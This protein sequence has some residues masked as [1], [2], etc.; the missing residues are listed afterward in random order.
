MRKIPT[1]A[2]RE[3][4]AYFFSPI[5]Y[6]V[7]MLFLAAAGFFFHVILVETQEATLRHTL[8][9]LNFIMI[10]VAPVLTMRLLAEEKRAGTLETL[11]TAP[12]TDWEV[13]LGKYLACVG[14]YLMLLLPTLVYVLILGKLGSPDYRQIATGYLGLILL[15]SLFLSFGMIA[16]ALTTNQIVAALL[17]FVPLLILWVV[18]WVV[19]EPERYMAAS[20]AS[21]RILK[22]V[23]GALRYV[24]VSGHLEGFFKGLVDTRDL[25][26]FVSLSGFF[27]FLTVRIMESRKW[28]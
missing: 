18:Y 27:L 21:E 1:I 7:G 24:G 2:R 28:K 6:V 15:G 12:V 23:F 22:V 11:M 25:I 4:S 13:V 20:S 5:A 10:F 3:L 19:P 16:S 14:F 8:G 17:S 26:Y 9:T